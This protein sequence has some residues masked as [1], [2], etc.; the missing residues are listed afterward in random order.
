MCCALLGRGRLCQ[1][2]W[3]G[4]RVQGC[5]QDTTCT[6]DHKGMLFCCPVPCAVVG[7]S[8]DLQ[9]MCVVAV[10]MA[11]LLKAK[12]ITKRMCVWCGAGREKMER[13]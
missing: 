9:N 13:L 10:G 5:S 2:G 8:H 6:E 12:L 7:R 11:Q 3:I 1:A 4:S